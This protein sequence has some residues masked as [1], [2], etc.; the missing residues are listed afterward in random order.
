MLSLN[1]DVCFEVIARRLSNTMLLSFYLVLVSV[2]R[3]ACGRDWLEARAE[4]ISKCLRSPRAATGDS[5]TLGR[6][7]GEPHS[8]WLS[9]QA[10]Q[11]YV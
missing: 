10:G 1:L 7:D 4:Q 2:V 8:G 5:D 9:C 11:G 6:Q 3:Q